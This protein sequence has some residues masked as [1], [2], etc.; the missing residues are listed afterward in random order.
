M[1]VGTAARAAAARAGVEQARK[2]VA[3]RWPTIV[4]A[5]PLGVSLRDAT[6][7]E[8]AAARQRSSGSDG[9]A[10]DAPLPARVKAMGK[11]ETACR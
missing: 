11:G 6:L 2:R 10:T 4:M 3:W 7:E 5:A 9:Q 1:P 8:L